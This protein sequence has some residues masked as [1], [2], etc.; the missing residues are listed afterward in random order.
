MQV[1]SDHTT[2]KSHC[3]YPHVIRSTEGLQHVVAHN[4]STVALACTYSE[5]S[6]IARA[7]YVAGE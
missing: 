5:V 7:M 1:V 6:H 3:Q 4:Y 2:I